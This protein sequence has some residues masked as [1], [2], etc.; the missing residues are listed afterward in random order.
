MSAIVHKEFDR[1]LKP[2]QRNWA[3]PESRSASVRPII[4]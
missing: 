4:R 3:F 2:R 1:N